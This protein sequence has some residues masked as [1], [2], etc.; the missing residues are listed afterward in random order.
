MDRR[1]E[2]DD[3]GEDASR[4][5]RG[6][7]RQVPLEAERVLERLHDRLDR[8]PDS[9]DLRIGAVG[10]V[11]AAR[12]HD[13][14]SQ[15]ARGL[16]DLAPGE[17]LAVEE[18]LAGNWFARDCQVSAASRRRRGF[19]LPG[20]ELPQATRPPSRTWLPEALSRHTAP[21]A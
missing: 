7:L 16:L 20:A 10:L 14:R 8:L 18:K 13:E 19:R 6:R 11:G 2:R 9:A 3:A 5:P 12:A 1:A 17:A 21:G 15:L 4:E